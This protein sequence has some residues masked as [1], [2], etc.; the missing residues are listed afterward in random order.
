VVSFTECRPDEL[1]SLIK[2]RPGLIRWSF[3][4]YG[5]AVQKEAFLNPTPVPVIYGGEEIF[6]DLPVERKYLFQLVKPGAKDWSAEREWRFPGDLRLAEIGWDRIT[7]IV[8]DL[9]EARM[10]QDRFGYRVTLSGILPKGDGR[11]KT[12]DNPEPLTY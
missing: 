8:T 3:E 6:R 11:K 4:A 7:V 12:Q 5:I 10:V 1:E 9:E 2:W